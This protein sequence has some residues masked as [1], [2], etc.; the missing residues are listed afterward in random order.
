MAD[1]T[2]KGRSRPK[3]APSPW[4][5]KKQAKPESG[6]RSLNGK[7]GYLFIA[8]FVIMFLIFGLYPVVYSTQLAFYTYDPLSLE[9]TF[10]GLGNFTDL[11][12][13]DRFWIA[14]GNTFE[15][16]ALSTFPQMA[17]A[18]GFAAI[19]R[20]RFLK[21]K[22]FWRTILLVPNITSVIAVAIIFG[23]LFGRDFGL[24]NLAIEK[25]GFEHIDFVE[26]S[27]ASHVAVATMITWRWVGYNSLIFLAAMVAIPNDLYE[28]ATLD[29]A[30]KWQTFRYVTL[31]QL[32]NTITF[33]LIVGTIGGL[34][35]FAEPLTLGGY[36]G[37][38]SRQFST[39][40]LFLYEQAFQN[41]RWGYAA[42]VGIMI[43]LI[44][45]VISGINFLIT[46][47]ISSEEN[48]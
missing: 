11:L 1:V 21:A 46:R 4:K 22:T 34:Q 39:L 13:D 31:P 36:S 44:V 47:R 26:N 2:V 14:L 32:K 24:I 7:W 23:Q 37:G 41:G 8:P 6:I 17:L 19:L 35:V 45:L 27:F 3:A 43:T 20:N 10:V 30:N 18:I 5:P 33:V 16:W 9:Q 25:F 48:K 38:D 42:A 40:T 29:G 15:I 28:S 12:A